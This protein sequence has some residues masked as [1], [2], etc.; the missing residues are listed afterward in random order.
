MSKPLDR[1]LAALE[2]V[3]GPNRWAAMCST[4]MEEWPP[5]EAAAWR[6]ALGASDPA[7][8]AALGLVSDADL[9]ALLAEAEKALEGADRTVDPEIWARIDELKAKEAA[10]GYRS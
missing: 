9:D 2:R 7:A 5:E 10:D 4:P 8:K 3:G 6:H 1:R